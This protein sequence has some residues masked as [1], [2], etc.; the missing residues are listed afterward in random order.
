[1]RSLQHGPRRAA[2]VAAIALVV[3]PVAAAAQ[4]IDTRTGGTI[5][6]SGGG[7]T[8]GETFV[9]PA[10]F[11]V[12]NAFS[13]WFAAGN[14]FQGFVYQWNGTTPVGGALF[15]SP[16]MAQSPTPPLPQQVTFNVG[17]LSLNPGSQYVAFVRTTSTG[18]G[19]EIAEVT[20][21]AYAAGSF[22]VGPSAPANPTAGNWTVI[23]NADDEFVATFAAPTVTAAPEPASLLLVGGGLAVLG[24]F[25]R[26]RRVR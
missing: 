2:L 23:P 12:L 1:M 4:T 25:A 16:V 20:P 13:L 10:G 21:D 6:I 3:G 19:M 24:L 14:P 15:A 8:S 9:A 11:P 18:G 5:V 17:S 22:V 26:R 7:Q